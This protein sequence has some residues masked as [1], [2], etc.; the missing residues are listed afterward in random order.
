MKIVDAE[1]TVDITCLI[2]NKNGSKYFQYLESYFLEV[3]DVNFEILV[4]DDN[5]TDFSLRLLNE[6]ASREPRL[7]FFSN[8]GNGLV[9]ALNFGL[10]KSSGTWIA[11]FDVDDKYSLTRLRDQFENVSQN[12]VLIFSDVRMIDS[13]DRVIGT[14]RAPLTHQEALVSFFSN[15]R[16]AHSSAFFHRNTSIK[17]GKYLISE[18]Y[19]EDM[20]LW[21]R[22]SDLGA[23]I[24]VPKILVEYRV[25]PSS[26]LSKNRKNAYAVRNTLRQNK[27]FSNVVKVSIA[28]FNLTMKT[29]EKQD[30]FASRQVLHLLENLEIA[31][32]Q[33]DTISVGKLMMLILK[34]WRIRHYRELCKLFLIRNRKNRFQ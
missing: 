11:R 9:D 15:R 3:K 4:V 21:L 32:Y 5:S 25:S 17:A 16:T 27:M 26:L 19:A 28:D 34:N 13:F 7:K 31:I 1:P 24:S 2:P 20:G 14:L 18:L 12:S 30:G 22:I 23:V 10:E 6:W 8:P 33:K 29:T